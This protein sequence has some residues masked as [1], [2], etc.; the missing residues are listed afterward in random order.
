LAANQAIVSIARKFF[1]KDVL[2]TAEG[3]HR[4][5]LRNETIQFIV[6][7][8]TSFNVTVKDGECTVR[9][10]QLKTAGLCLS[11]DTDTYLE[12]FEGRTTLTEAWSSKRI[13]FEGLQR[14][15]ESYIW[16]LPLIRIGQGKCLCV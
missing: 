9:A 15:R 11:A 10:G 2:R 12:L 6:T 16:F 7:D 3:E 5:R 13:R 1:K 8:G 4:I 14:G